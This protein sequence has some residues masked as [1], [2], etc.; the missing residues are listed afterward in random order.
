MQ[1]KEAETRVS[2]MKRIALPATNEELLA[3][4]DVDTFRAG[5]RVASM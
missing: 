1:P 4:C 3:E 2:Q 5:A